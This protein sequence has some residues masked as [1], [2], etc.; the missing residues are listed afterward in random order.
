[1]H[2]QAQLTLISSESCYKRLNEQ[3]LGTT[4]KRGINNVWLEAVFKNLM[5]K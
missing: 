4:K 1:M 5:T 2:K 3:L